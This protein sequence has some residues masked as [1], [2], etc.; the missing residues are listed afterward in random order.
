MRL[1]FLIGLLMG[2]S[3]Y[4][5]TYAQGYGNEHGAAGMVGRSFSW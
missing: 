3:D 1:F 4:A 5:G 2:L